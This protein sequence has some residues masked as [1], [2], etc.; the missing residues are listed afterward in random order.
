MRPHQALRF[1]SSCGNKL[2]V[3]ARSPECRSCTRASAAVPVESVPPVV[4]D[5]FWT[6]AELR[7]A[8]DAEDFGRVLKAYRRACGPDVTQTDVAG[9]IGLSQSQVSRMESGTSLTAD[10]GKIAEWAKA[11]RIP[12]DFL[13]FTVSTEPSHAY[14]SVMVGSTLLSSHDV[15]GDDVQR[16][17]F[18]KVAAVAGV[19]FADRSPVGGSRQLA[20]IPPKTAGSP[21]VDI[22]REMTSTFRKIDNKHGG[23]HSHVRMAVR[24][25]L[26]STKPLA[27]GQSNANLLAAKAELYQLAG[28]IDYDTGHL[29][30]GNECLTTALELCRQAGDYAL[31]AEM[32]AAMSHHA[33][34]F[35][36]TNEFIKTK[37]G[38][39]DGAHGAAAAVS[40]ATAARLSA[41][42][43]GLWALQSEAAAMEA[44]GLALRRDRH[45][46]VKALLD[47]ERAFE[48][49]HGQEIPAWLS[50]FDAAY[51][52]AKFAHTLRDLGQSVEAEQ[53]AR[54][55][56]EMSDGYDRGRLF[57]TVL[58]ASTIA[59]Q[60]RVEEACEVGL[61]AVQMSDAVR[62][63]RVVYNLADLGHR[64]GTF[65]GTP[66]VRTLFTEMSKRGIPIPSPGV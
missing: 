31:E 58:L 24:S 30:E 2:A 27:S 51:L 15:E 26:D 50:Y 62:S 52:S 4:P 35:S 5:S 32:L 19:G 53:F 12:Q 64:L 42:R 49:I 65:Q 47:A 22:V 40:H 11:L 29:A 43:S 37:D 6:T 33:A 1:C 10:I 7:E 34:F 13:W 36:Q 28:W 14:R 21:D 38:R 61:H 46:S 63:V 39:R 20:L 55:S 18:L 57:N 59:D 48:R 45:E 16:R 17:G 23:G 44:H 60:R 54:R 56:L 41:K 3:G 9:W 8:F 25:Y 66:A